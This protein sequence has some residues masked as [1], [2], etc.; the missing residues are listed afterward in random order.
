MKMARFVR[1]H[2]KRTEAKILARAFTEIR[3]N[4]GPDNEV[5]IQ[6][7]SDQEDA[8]FGVFLSE[9]EVRIAAERLR[10]QPTKSTVVEADV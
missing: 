4:G 8:W 7:R 2:V 3:Y 9:C 6:A 10:L 1:R 5:F